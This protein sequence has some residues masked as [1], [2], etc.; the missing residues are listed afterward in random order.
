[1]LL[2]EKGWS[3]NRVQGWTEVQFLWHLGPMEEEQVHPDPAATKHPVPGP[4]IRPV[5]ETSG[6]GAKSGKAVQETPW[7]HLPPSTC[8]PD[9]FQG[10]PSSRSSTSHQGQSQL[11]GNNHRPQ[12]SG[13]IAAVSQS[14]NLWFQSHPPK[15]QPPQRGLPPPAREAS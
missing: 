14:G 5:G 3:A 8:G 4:G 12:A 15:Q 9:G 1:M 7:F 11:V 13:T 6:R 2:G 10:H